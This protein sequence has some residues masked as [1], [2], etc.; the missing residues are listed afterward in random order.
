MDY[1]VVIGL[2]IHAELRTRAKLFTWSANLF[3]GEPNTRTDPITLGLPGVLPVLNRAALEHAVTAGLA[4]HCSIAPFSK[5]DRKHYFYPDLPKG[6]QISQ[7]DLPLAH[8]GYVDFD[9]DGRE[10]RCRIRRVH[11][12]E[13]AGKLVHAPGAGDVSWVDFNRAGV[14]LIEIVG[15]PD[16][17]SPEE[18]IA[19]WR[20]IK[21]TLEY[22]GVS[23]CNME[24]GSYRCDANISLRPAGSE[25]LGTRAELKNMNS[26]RHVL[27]ALEYEVE[28][29]RAVLDSG[30][31]VAQETRLFDV[32]TGRTRAMRGKEEAHDYRYF[33]EPDLVPMEVDPAWVEEIRVSLPELPRERR[34][35]IVLQYGIPEY[36][37]VVL[38]A[39]RAVAD[40]YEQVASRSGDAKAASNWVMG[41]FAALLKAADKSVEESPVPAEHLAEMIRLIAEGTI[42]GK[43]GK[44]VLEEM[45]ASGKSPSSVIREQGLVQ[46]TDAEAI[47]A[48]VDQVIAEH[49]GPAAEVR[50]GNERPLR[51]LVGQVMRLSRGKA[52]PTL[53][54]EL[55]ARVLDAEND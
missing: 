4:L 10:R 38:T 22:L 17:R 34:R 16:L 6:Y 27:R 26:F 18:A 15:E 1:D 36:D 55:L 9:A 20:T 53:V 37:A 43:I 46:V 54:N 42:S 8:G 33:A 45:F 3:G 44:S 49:P 14:P 51:F 31:Q 48:W 23:D 47:Q 28:R 19:Y 2:E 7:Y 24:E 39:T 13:D 30:G 32:E 35:R 41:D 52:N 21:E 29:Q 12:E 5:F 40:Y 25:D 50:G 11:L